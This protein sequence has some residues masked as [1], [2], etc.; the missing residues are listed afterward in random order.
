MY[1]ETYLVAC[2]TC[3][4]FHTPKPRRDS[5][6]EWHDVFTCCGRT[7]DVC[8]ADEFRRMPRRTLPSH[9]EQVKD[10]YAVKASVWSGGK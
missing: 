7:W 10:I 2:P 9:S 3:H 4:K 6:N 1:D 5:H 8:C